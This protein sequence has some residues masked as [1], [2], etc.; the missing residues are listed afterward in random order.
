MFKRLTRLVVIEPSPISPSWTENAVKERQGLLDKAFIWSNTAL[1]EADEPLRVLT[2]PIDNASH[3]L[4]FCPNLERAICHDDMSQHIL[5]RILRWL[6]L[7]VL[8]LARSYYAL[9]ILLVIL[10]LSFGL[11]I[12]FLLGRKYEKNNQQQTHSQTKLGINRFASWY[13]NFQ[14]WIWSLFPMYWPTMFISQSFTKDPEADFRRQDSSTCANGQIRYQKVNPIL[15]Q[16]VNDIE[17]FPGSEVLSEKEDCARVDLRSDR[18]MDRESGV[19]LDDVPRHVAV[20]MDGNRRYGK[21]KYGNA[22]SGHWEGSRKLLQFAK[23]CIAEGIQHLTVYAFSTENWKRDPSEVAALM[24]I[25]VKYCEELRTEA[26]QRNIRVRV[27]STDIHPIPDA[28]KA[29]LESLEQDTRH[30]QGL[31]MNVCLSYGS[32]AEILNACRNL[33]RDC[34]HGIISPDKITEKAF[35]EALLSRHSPDPDVVIRTSGELRLSNFLL[36]QSAYT[37]FFFAHKNWPE[38]EKDDLLQV[39]HSYASRKRRFGR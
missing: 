7:I 12:G 10:P 20:I 1:E 13:G 38:F 35:G 30:C 31:Q 8:K 11:V 3:R 39:I 33:A 15:S 17:F 2:L 29:G 25:F 26:I 5:E 34:L 37:E 28:V 18:E 14:L 4:S 16:R 6:K 19:P 24:T 23:W 21:I 36:W 22:T 32:R 9:P 27:L